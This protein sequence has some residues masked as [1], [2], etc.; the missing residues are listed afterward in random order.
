MAHAWSGPEQPVPYTEE[1]VSFENPQANVRLAG[2]L[3]LPRGQS[4]FPAVVLVAGSGPVNRDEELFGH[5]PFAV[6][7]DHLTRR[8]VAVFRYDK[9]GVAGSTGDFSQATTMD[10]AEDAAAGWDYLAARPDIDRE[11]IGA[12]GH[13]EGGMII[14]T[15]AVERPGVAFLVMLAG[16]GMSGGELE[17]LQNSLLGQAKGVGEPELAYE[18]ETIRQWVA[19]V[20]AGA[21]GHEIER[22]LRPRVEVSSKGHLE[23]V[24]QW[25]ARFHAPWW[26]F[27]LTHSAMPDLEKVRCPVMA[28]NGSKD[29]QVPPKENLGPIACAL[30][31]G[32][33]TDF[34]IRELP[35]L[36]HLFQH[37]E[38][39][40]EA[41]YDLI[42]ETIA[43]EVLQMVGDW[44]SQ[45]LS[46]Q[47]TPRTVR[48]QVGGDPSR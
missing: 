10:F 20:A 32:G 37:A 30:A 45:H 46:S 21:K 1:D 44:I 27:I 22:V 34:V 19:M 39:G 18:Q 25:V 6:L 47:P 15:L 42:T 36:N 23:E 38:T 35:G 12:V 5:R 14:P 28:L 4:P 17:A 31:A 24:K 26:Q 33:N 41:E 43:P 7:A 8:W 40:S 3:T 13:S 29:L 48:Q 11:Q 16:V 2:T 9:R